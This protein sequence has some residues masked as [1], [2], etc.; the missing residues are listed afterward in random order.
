MVSTAV[1]KDVFWTKNG[2]SIVETYVRKRIL[3]HKEM[4]K[5]DVVILTLVC[6]AGHDDIVQILDQGAHIYNK[7]KLQPVV[8]MQLCI[9][10]VT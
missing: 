8:D 4:L 5:N 7:Q 3:E 9:R 6:W 2:K 10:A 1:R